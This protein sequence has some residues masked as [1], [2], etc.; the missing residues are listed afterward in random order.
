MIQNDSRDLFWNIWGTVLIWSFREILQE[1]YAL[2][3]VVPGKQT[4]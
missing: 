3:M 2:P 1:T 4:G